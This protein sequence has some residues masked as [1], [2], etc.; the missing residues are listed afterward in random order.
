MQDLKFLFSGHAKQGMIGIKI[1]SGNT[2]IDLGACFE[3]E[4]KELRS[5]LRKAINCLNDVIESTES[6][7]D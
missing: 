2:E 4:A 6:I 1:K 3:I 5:E 7:G